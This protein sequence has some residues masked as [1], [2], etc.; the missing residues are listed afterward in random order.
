MRVL[1]ACLVLTWG[2]TPPEV[3]G[4]P[5]DG[6]WSFTDRTR[7]WGLK[8]VAGTRLAA[9]DVDGDGWTDLVVSEGDAF[10][11]DDFAAGERFHHLLLNRPDGEGGRTFED[12]TVASG[13][14]QPRKG[15]AAKVGRAS[16][17][18][19]FGDLD[20]DGDLDV[21]AGTFWDGSKAADDTGDRTEVLLNDGAG[22]FTLAARTDAWVAEGYA[23]TGLSLVDADA[24]GALDLWMTGWYHVYGSLP[25]EQ[26]RLLLGD[27]AG[28]FANATGPRGL[29]MDEGAS[30]ATWLDGTARRPAF[31]ATA[32]DLDGDG[33]EDLLASNYA[34]SWNQ[35][36]MQQADGTFVDVARTSGFSDDGLSDVS[37]N[38]F[39]RCWCTVN[40]CDPDPGPA[41]IDCEG[42]TSSWQAG[43]DDQPHRQGGNTFGTVCADLDDDGD[44]DLLNAEIAHWWAGEASDRSQI[45]VNDGT[46]AFT[47][48]GLEATGLLRTYETA[49]WDEGDLFAAAADLDLDGDKDLL[50]AT[51][52]YP[53]TRLHVFR[54]D[55]T[56]RYAE[57]AE[58][59]GLAHPWPASLAVADFDRDGDLDV[60]TG[61]ST[62]RSGTPWEAHEVH[63]YVNGVQGGNRLRLRLEGDGANRTG[64]GA[65]VV[66]EAGGVRRHH[67]IDGGQGHMAMQHDTV[68]TLGLGD[69]CTAERVEVTWPGGQ[70]DAYEGVRAGWEVTLVQGGELRHELP[71][72]PASG[73]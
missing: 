73:G 55:D 54:A 53:G 44:A 52:D 2:C 29:K 10:G 56:L 58:A 26:D 13:L 62:S 35:Q 1:L 69:A 68:L 28:G 61:S 49:S 8:G 27:G 25:S 9:A 47:R 37:G 17:L 57:V 7:A 6:A 36:W 19:V 67:R 51:T 14:F 11:R 41:A 72:E 30:R 40:A 50:L 4:D 65:R 46:G 33:R 42:N 15:D 66:V 23:T 43:W 64:L 20:G 12:A 38:Q 60:V 34:R 45:L 59:A 63:L 16:M 22:V 71:L 3:C 70:V 39:Y 48:P 31:G 5:V 24:D 18:H 32:C 21:V